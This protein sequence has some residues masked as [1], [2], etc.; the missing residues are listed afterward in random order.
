[1]KLLTEYYKLISLNEYLSTK[2]KKKQNG[3]DSV[4]A[5][6]VDL[7]TLLYSLG[8]SF[9]DTQ[10]MDDGAIW[11]TYTYSDELF[12]IIEDAYHDG[13]SV[14][15]LKKAFADKYEECKDK[16][17]DIQMHKDSLPT[18]NYQQF[19]LKVFEKYPGPRYQEICSFCIYNKN[20]GDKDSFCLV[21]CKKDSPELMEKYLS[22]IY[23]L[24]EKVFKK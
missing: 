13:N 17:V 23:F 10:V 18:Y 8:V 9:K 7:D 6:L 4:D 16:V 24:I 3:N 12:G 2:A 15:S 22:Y 14:F 19:E 20:D 1:M 11:R 5:M 21:E